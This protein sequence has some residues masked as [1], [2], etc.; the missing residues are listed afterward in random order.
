MGFAWHDAIGGLGVA[1]IVLTYLLLLLERLDARG[2]SYSFLNG[3]GAALVIFSLMYEFNL[4][5]F[6][7]ELFWLLISLLGLVMWVRRK[8]NQEE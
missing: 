4:S 7:I 1:I 3:I 2:L 8:S 5:A 6:L